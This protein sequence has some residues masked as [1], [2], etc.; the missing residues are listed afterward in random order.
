MRSLPGFTAFAA[1][2]ARSLARTALSLTGDEAAARALTV[3]ALTAVAARWSAVR[4]SFPV[5][6]ARAALYES[7]LRSPAS[8]GRGRGRSRPAPPAFAPAGADGPGA[9][10]PLTARSAETQDAPPA[11]AGGDATALADA[12]AGL[13]P[14][15]RALVVACFHDG[16]TTWQ[17][18][19]LCGMDARAANTETV[20]AVADLR[21][22]LPASFTTGTAS[23]PDGDDLASP[24]P[25]PPAVP[26]ATM[27]TSPSGDPVAPP[28]AASGLSGAP[29]PGV[30]E[31][32]A[33]PGPAA[34]TVV[35]PPRQ[36]DGPWEAALRRELAVLSAAMPVLDPAPIAA[37]AMRAAARRGDTRRSLVTSTGLTLAALIVVPFA[38]GVAGLAGQVGGVLPGSSEEHAAVPGTL[39]PS[40]RDP[41]RFAYRGYCAPSVWDR[42]EGTEEAARDDGC[43]Q[44][45]IVTTG[46]ERWRVAD[47]ARD[48]GGSM[49]PLLAIS[50][51]GEHVAYY[52]EASSD[53]VV[54][55]RRHTTPEETGV[56][57][58]GDG[59][60]ED[61]HL[62]IS[63][64]GRWIAADFGRAPGAR[65]PRLHDSGSHRT[66]TLPRRVRV[67]AIGDDGTVTGTSGTT[68]L[69]MRPDGRA[70]SGVRID[71]GLFGDDV[72]VSPDGYAV[73]MPADSA[74]PEGHGLVVT[75]DTATGKVLGRREV[76]LPGNSR[77]TA[78]RGWVNDHEVVV[79]AGRIDG[80]DDEEHFTIHAVDVR[81]GTARPLDLEGAG[82]VPAIWVPGA[83]H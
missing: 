31:P 37:E 60:P 38:F 52:S 64:G 46:G 36:G 4:W 73:A 69:R 75:V 8:R 19:G 6:A 22:L 7:Y 17:A 67:L 24:Q 57:T 54:L 56:A 21:H 10:R 3:A 78:V 70:V 49:Q 1:D 15:R 14:Q 11:G 72:A 18:A 62:V 53:F 26:A 12:L 82:G 61:A 25:E 63:P 20:L 80:A 9:A 55:D 35:V 68:L 77:L 79:E 32:Y 74:G 58:G 33:A 39:P 23:A 47:M 76:D 44:W 30:T 51:D 59:P 41:V 66:W 65:R 43:D 81:T 28:G 42:I 71:A 27:W 45:R 13:T 16:C 83:L 50:G 34:A 29:F 5:H 48:L 2:Q 40:L